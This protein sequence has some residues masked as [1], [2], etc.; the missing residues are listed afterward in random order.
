MTAAPEATCP[1]CGR[2]VSPQDNFCEACRA[3]L[4][5][6]RLSGDTPGAARTCPSCQSG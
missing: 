1:S 4:A 6:A 2:A 5:P 3:E